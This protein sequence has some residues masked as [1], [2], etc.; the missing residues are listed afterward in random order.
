MAF[1]LEIDAVAAC[2]SP[3]GDRRQL[4]LFAGR[5]P[6]PRRVDR[7]PGQNGK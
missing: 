1:L 5:A 3:S 7:S 2:A 6:P 4:G